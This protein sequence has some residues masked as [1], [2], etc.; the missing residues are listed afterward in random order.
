[1]QKV[2]FLDRDGVINVEKDYLYKVEDFEFIDGILDLC[3]YYES[4]GYIIAVVTNQSGIAREF[5]TEEDFLI[6][7]K[8]MINEFSNNGV[9]ISKV[10]HC[11]HH[12][13][14]SGICECRKPHP[15]MLLRLEEEFDVDYA[16]SIII[17]DKERDIEAGL[18]AGIYETY[19]FS[20][21]NSISESKATKIVSNL[22]DI[23][24]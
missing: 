23:W 9:T 2:L 15:G 1:M 20:E 22:N 4:Y 19:L 17:G 3:K 16:N 8:W 12:P 7:T 6:L 14:I 11:P 10:Y 21:D 18:N 24:K 5:Y 13:S